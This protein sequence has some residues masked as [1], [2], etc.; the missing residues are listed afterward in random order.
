MG[1]DER[2]FAD[3]LDALIGLIC[4]DTVPE[5]EALAFLH[6]LRADIERRLTRRSN[7]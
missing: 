2:W 1:K 6:D 3:M 5:G 4:V 7:G